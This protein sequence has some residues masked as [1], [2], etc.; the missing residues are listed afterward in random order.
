MK[1][2]TVSSQKEIVCHIF[3]LYLQE[4]SHS[5][6]HALPTGKFKALP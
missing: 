4:D 6:Y 5:E 3:I 1:W 2:Q